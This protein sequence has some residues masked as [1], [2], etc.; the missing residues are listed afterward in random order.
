MSSYEEKFMALA[1]AGHAMT[2]EID[3]FVDHW[4]ADPKGLALHEY[5][6]M[7]REEYALWLNSPDM[8]PLI[9][10]SRKTNK[11]LASVANDNLQEMRIAARA[12]DT[13][14]IKLLQRW[15]MERRQS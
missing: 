5:L 6:G 14:K 11:S 1:L 13:Q 10:A 4:H 8:L 15:L 7:D 9:V 2:D 12:D 3:D